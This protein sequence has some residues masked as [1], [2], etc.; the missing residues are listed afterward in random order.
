MSKAGMMKKLKHLSLIFLFIIFFHGCAVM[1]SV[2]L[3]TADTVPPGEIDLS[4]EM[5]VNTVVD[6][7]LADYV[8]SDTSGIIISNPAFPAP[9]VKLS[10]SIDENSDLNIKS[11]LTL[12][13]AGVKIY[14]KNQLKQKNPNVK[15]AF[16]PGIIFLKTKPYEFPIFSTTFQ[17]FA[18]GFELPYIHTRYVN[19]VVKI[20]GVARYGFNQLVKKIDDTSQVVNF[21]RIGFSGGFNFNLKYFRINL[22][23][24]MDFITTLNGVYAVNPIGGIGITF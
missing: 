16:A 7:Y 10:L 1:D 4:V 24:G 9:A 13:G 21:H 2:Y 14:F 8:S 17:Y 11:W 6:T 3:E 12:N 23:A 19:N 18:Y 22:L 15:S 20:T 5:S